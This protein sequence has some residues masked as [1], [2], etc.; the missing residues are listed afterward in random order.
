MRGAP[1]YAAAP[2][3]R[4]DRSSRPSHGKTSSARTRLA[5]PAQRARR[6]DSGR[7]LPSSLRGRAEIQPRTSFRPRPAPPIGGELRAPALVGRQTLHA[8]EHAGLATL[9]AM[10]FL[11]TSDGQFHVMRWGS[12]TAGD[13]AGPRVQP[14]CPLLGGGRTTLGGARRTVVA[15]TQRGH[16][17]SLRSPGNYSREV[18]TQDIAR[19]P[20]RW[21]CRPSRSWA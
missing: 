8:M 20:M 9:R 18:M 11:T 15:F 17:D 13:A 6:G 12:R 16:G 3:R 2:H 21:S 10:D 7:P 19:L 14:D 5:R 1:G 4:G